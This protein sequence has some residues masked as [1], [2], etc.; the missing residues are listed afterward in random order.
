MVKPCRLSCSCLLLSKL[1]R[2]RVSCR[3]TGCAIKLLRSGTACSLS[4]SKGDLDDLGPERAPV[5]LFGFWLSW[6][7]RLPDLCGQSS[8]PALGA[9]RGMVTVRRNCQSYCG[10]CCASG[11]S[12]VVVVVPFP[13]AIGASSVWYGSLVHSGAVLC[14]AEAVAARRSTFP[15][16]AS[17]P[18][19]PTPV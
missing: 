13:R 5:V 6:L 4:I 18:P 7:L 11:G 14:C 8:F 1:T 10:F 15:P 16:V 19:S 9:D 3:Q 12:P 2:L 17:K